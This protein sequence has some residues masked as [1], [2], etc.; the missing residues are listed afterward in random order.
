M[1]TPLVA[2]QHDADRKLDAFNEW[3]KDMVKGGGSRVTRWTSARFFHG[4]VPGLNLYELLLPADAL[5]SSYSYSHAANVY[6]GGWVYVTS[7][8]ASARAYAAR[9]LDPAGFSR[10]GDVYEVRALD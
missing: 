6:D 9:Y 5:G 7:Q 4:G 3:T 1:E 10:P 2:Q 8:F